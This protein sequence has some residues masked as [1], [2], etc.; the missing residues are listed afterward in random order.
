MFKKSIVAVVVIVAVAAIVFAA[1][2]NL[3]QDNPANSITQGNQESSSD[4]SSTSDNATTET[5]I[6]PE[7]AQKIAQKYIEVQRATAGTPKLIKTNGQ[8][9]YAVPVI[10]NGTN[11]GEIDIDAQTGKNIGGAGGAP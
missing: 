4:N 1:S 10:D 9:Y 11:V 8:Y 2:G 6:S 3:G 7:E 5:K